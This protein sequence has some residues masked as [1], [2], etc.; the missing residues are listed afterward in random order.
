MRT[1]ILSIAIFLSGLLAERC[2]GQ[3]LA[4]NIT[5]GLVVSTTNANTIAN[6]QKYRFAPDIQEMINSWDKGAE[7]NGMSCAVFFT[8]VLNW[9]LPPICCV[10]LINDTT[11]A[12]YGG[13]RPSPEMLFKIDLFDSNNIP[14]AKTDMGKKYGEP[15]T[16]E[17]LKEWYKKNVNG[18]GWGT[19]LL[20][21]LSARQQI[22]QFSIPEVFQLKQTGEYTLH[23]NMRLM[24]SQHDSSGKLYFSIIWLPEVAAKVQIQPED[25]ASTNLPPSNSQ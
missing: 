1:I 15:V 7:T 13:F 21:P 12:F 5:N 6:E 18:R 22:S 23:L 20:P 19:F 2:D 10:N 14:V 4:T 11:N 17:Q 25:I 8:R 9:K 3:P 16:Q 24:Q